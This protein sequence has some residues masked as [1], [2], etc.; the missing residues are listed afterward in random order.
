MNLLD[1]AFPVGRIAGINIRVHTLFILWIAYQLMTAQDWRMELE[2]YSVVFGIVVLHELGHCF[3]ARSVG[4]DAKEILLWPLGGLAFAGAPM[5]A[6]PQFVTV[7]AGP[8]V[9]VLICAI[10]G[11]IVIKT[12][13]TISLHPWGRTLPGTGEGVGWWAFLFYYLSMYLFYFN[14]LPI[15][16]MD[17]GQLLRAIL[18]PYLGLRQATIIATQMGIVGAGL[19]GVYGFQQ[20]SPLLI[21][22]AIWGGM[23]AFQHY[24]FARLGYLQDETFGSDGVGHVFRRRS[25]WSRLFRGRSAGSDRA[26]AENPNP[27]G[28]ERKQTELETLDAEVDRILAKVHERGKD[29]LTYAEVK[30]LERAS[31]LRKDRDMHGGRV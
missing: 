26:A 13:G 30:T 18:W 5:R 3:G 4:G 20:Q 11:V 15:F 12:G 1:G 23:T 29:A 10:C 22:M 19:L 17:G 7:A 31:R 2:M 27:G 9:N 6:W 24:Q 8:A 14:I 16:P 21:V 25:L 28:W